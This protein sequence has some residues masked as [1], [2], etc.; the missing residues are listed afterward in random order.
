MSTIY[1]LTKP[2]VITSGTYQGVVRLKG[3]ESFFDW[4][5]SLEIF[6]RGKGRSAACMLGTWPEPYRR[7]LT[8]HPAS[9]PNPVDRVIRPTHEKAGDVPPRG[10]QIDPLVTATGAA[11][12][13]A[14][15]TASARLSPDQEKL[16]NIWA[17]AENAARAAI[18]STVSKS[19][20]GTIQDE[21]SSA[22]MLRKLHI[23][24]TASDSE[25]DFM[26]I[27]AR[28]RGL[29]MTE[30]PTIEDMR[31]YLDD[32]TTIVNDAKEAGITFKDHELK[33]KF[34]EGLSYSLHGSM[35]FEEKHAPRAIPGRHLTWSEFIAAYNGVIDIMIGQR[36]HQALAL[37][38]TSA[39]R[40]DAPAAPPKHVKNP[41]PLDRAR[42]QH[43][44]RNPVYR[45]GKLR[46]KPANSA[47]KENKENKKYEP[48]E[49]CGRRHPPP[50]KQ[51][52][53]GKPSR[54]EADDKM[55]KEFFQFRRLKQRGL[56]DV[57]AL[58]TELENQE[59]CP[60]DHTKEEDDYGHPQ[61]VD[62]SLDEELET[63]L[64]LVL[65]PDIGDVHHVYHLTDDP[66]ENISDID[67]ADFKD[68][69]YF[70][71]NPAAGQ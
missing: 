45:D 44:S 65:K 50:C 62:D 1:E 28:F 24:F 39:S 55:W 37:M 6:L 29:Y 14:Q 21:W 70:F 41:T 35:T 66:Y 68:D 11:A 20:A 30:D 32:F 19:I 27:S 16:W 13:A 38:H 34:L 48:C 59:A 64:H 69:S 43:A 71:L 42:T 54:K 26:L 61:P 4:K 22:D 31:N 60:G 8:S 18:L 9:P 67:E 47:D 36:T 46:N 33:Q 3:R 7:N 10:L 5:H 52:E 63:A 25:A 23:N 53:Q 57:N 15:G 49:Y 40:N 2:E 17:L 51:E 12:I 56:V 58:M